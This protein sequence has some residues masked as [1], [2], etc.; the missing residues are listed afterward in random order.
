M[1]LACRGSGPLPTASPSSDTDAESSSS[2]QPPADPSSPAFPSCSPPAAGVRAVLS[3][4][5]RGAWQ[6]G[7]QAVS[8][9]LYSLA[10]LDPNA[11]VAPGG[12]AAAL[13]RRAAQVAKDMSAQ[14]V[15]NTAWACAV[16]R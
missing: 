3:S 13:A 1:S 5:H 8:V 6:W 15:A 7:P 12:G 9:V 14:S 16:L 2:A 10:T 11:D 4:A